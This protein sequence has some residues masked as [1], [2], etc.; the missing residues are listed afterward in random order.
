MLTL[1]YV[2]VLCC[3]C[4]GAYANR[5]AWKSNT[6]KNKGNI[7][8]ARRTAIIASRVAFVGIIMG[9]IMFSALIALVVVTW[10]YGS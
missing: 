9:V 8:A 4:V 7:D 5:Q 3:L 6:Q 1:T 2:S 10:D